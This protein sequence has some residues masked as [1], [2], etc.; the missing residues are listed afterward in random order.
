MPA[1]LESIGNE[2]LITIAVDC[3]PGTAVSCV[4][5]LAKIDL[6]SIKTLH[7]TLRDLHN[8]GVNLLGLLLWVKDRCDAA[9]N[10]MTLIGCS[11]KVSA[12]LAMT[13]VAD[14]FVCNDL[15]RPS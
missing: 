3:E 1:Q 15:G 10:R 11:E 8:I 5:Q 6:A 14:Q 13:N 7:I 9:D 4:R 2:L 12:I